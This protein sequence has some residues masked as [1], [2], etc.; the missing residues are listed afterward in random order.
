MMNEARAEAARARAREYFLKN[1]TQATVSVIRARIG[2]ALEALE[3]FLDAVP[4]ALAA[5]RAIEGEWTIH[6]V[7]DHLVETDRP[8]LDELWCLLAGRRP[9]GEAIPAGL[10]S[11]APLTRPWP[12]LLRELKRLHAD[13]LEAIAGAPQDFTT[14]AR[15]AIVMV[16]NVEDE[17]GRPVP[18]SWVEELDWK[19]YAIVQRLH[20]IDHLNQAKKVL[21]AAQGQELPGHRG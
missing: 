13:L 19:S 20:A 5:R 16:V 12:W 14:E 10:R 7:V 17:V 2:A 15:A 18:L 3:R 11:K 21:A 1:G 8:T 9:P 4:P 6:E